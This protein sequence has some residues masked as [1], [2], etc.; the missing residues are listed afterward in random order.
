MRCRHTIILAALL[1]GVLGPAGAGNGA[2]AATADVHRLAIAS[3]PEAGLEIYVDDVARGLR[4]PQVLSLPAGQHRLRLVAPPFR[5]EPVWQTE[6]GDG[7]AGD[8][9]LA[10]YGQTRV[11]E[12]VE[13][14]SAI[15]YD[16]TNVALFGRYSL[17]ATNTPGAKM[18]AQTNLSWHWLSSEPGKPWIRNDLE[19]RESL[20]TV[21]TYLTGKPGPEP[22]WISLATVVFD[23]GWESNTEVTTTDI[24]AK[25]MKIREWFW[26]D[27]GKFTRPPVADA[28]PYPLD[29][30]VK[31]ALYTK[32]DGTNSLVKVFQDDRLVVEARDIPFRRANTRP[33]FMHWGGYASAGNGPLAVYNSRTTVERVVGPGPAFSI[34]RWELDGAPFAGRTNGVEIHLAADARLCA[35][36]KKEGE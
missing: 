1:L 18:R 23:A 20:I 17:Q 27:S 30:W 21:W 22:N 16:A 29:K 32:L 7:T 31:V 9:V 8:F 2:A 13:P 6:Y 19:I 24:H 36:G 10:K 28:P 14:G 3:Q 11:S 15:R 12:S 34:A 33:D 5:T 25:D 35:F 4:T 26:V